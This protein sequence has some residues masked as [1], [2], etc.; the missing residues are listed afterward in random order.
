MNGNAT[1]R[2]NLP[3]A[4]PLAVGLRLNAN[5]DCQPLAVDWKRQQAD[6]FR[7]VLELGRMSLQE[8]SYALGYADQGTVSKWASATER[9]Q[10]DRIAGLD[11]L[12]PWI[13]VAWG[14][15]T[16]ADVHV[17]VIVRRTA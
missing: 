15:Q 1:A 11:Q 6:V 16:G 4:K 14:E 2:L 5:T 12:R 8:L 10:W 9:P 17:S 13:A 3:K 7:R